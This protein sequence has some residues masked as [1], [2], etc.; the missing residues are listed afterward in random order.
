MLARL[1]KITLII[2]LFSMIPANIHAQRKT[3]L[4]KNKSK[5]QVAVKQNKRESVDLGLSVKWATCNIGAS[6]P[7]DSGNYY[8]WGHTK[9]AK[10]YIGQKCIDTPTAAPLPRIKVSANLVPQNDVAHVQWGGSWR[11][12]TKEEALELVNLCSWERVTV[13]DV[14]GYKVTGP[15]GN[16]I[17]LPSAGYIGIN[18]IM[19]PNSCMY[20]TSTSS[21]S[22]WETTFYTP[23]VYIIN[24]FNEG[25]VIKNVTEETRFTGL[26]VRP[27]TE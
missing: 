13:D 19:S 25:S 5:K 11:M 7:S 12:P 26:P 14:V 1:S 16:S 21:D 15:N 20:W 4:R 9:T 2:L 23:L 8:W 24:V 27:V 17:F 10:N 22:K 6:K 18:S 3:S